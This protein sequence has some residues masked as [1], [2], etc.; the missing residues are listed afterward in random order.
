LEESRHRLGD[1]TM[2]EWE[3][4]DKDIR[5]SNLEQVAYMARILES[6]GYNVAPIGQYSESIQFSEEDLDAL[7]EMEHGRWNIERLQQ[8]WRYGKD[9]DPDKRTSP[10][11][12]RWEDLD[13]KTKIWDRQAVFKFAR[14]LPEIGMQIVRAPL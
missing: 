13:E 10:Y 1:R 2:R 6:V 14:L 3:N 12:I 8:G 7:G 5:K 4:L 9:R 11:L